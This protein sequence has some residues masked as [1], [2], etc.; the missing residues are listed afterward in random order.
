MQ[1]GGRK[2]FRNLRDPEYRF[3]LKLFEREPDLRNQFENRVA[4]SDGYITWSFLP[5]HAHIVSKHVSRQYR[6]ALEYARFTIAV[7]LLNRSN[8]NVDYAYIEDLKELASK[9]IE[10]RRRGTDNHSGFLNRIWEWL[11]SE[12]TTANHEEVLQL[13]LHILHCFDEKQE[14]SAPVEGMSVERLIKN[15]Y[16]FF[17]PFIKI[18]GTPVP[19]ERTA[20]ARGGNRNF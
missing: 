16:E 17:I 5:G 2:K 19:V 9:V 10:K 1:S 18:F 12:K 13:W 7:I 4:N 11:W 14:V 6:M 3:W 20:L 15:V 8:E